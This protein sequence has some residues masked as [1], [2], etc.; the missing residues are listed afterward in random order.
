MAKGPSFE[1]AIKTLEACVEHL[2][3]DD[4]PID[5]ALK[6]FETG[7]KNVQKCQKALEGARLKIEQLTRDQNQQLT[8]E[9][10]D[11]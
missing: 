1:D 8:T 4:L 6:Q 5:E 2:E 3:Q 11:L 7:V 9:T 10:L